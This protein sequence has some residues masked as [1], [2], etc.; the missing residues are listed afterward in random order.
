MKPSP[1]PPRRPAGPSDSLRRQ[2]SMSA[3]AA[4]AA[5][6]GM[7]PLGQPVEAKVVY[8]PAH[9]WL[10]LNHW[11]D[12]DLNHD[13]VN[14][15]TFLLGSRASTTGG[16]RRLSVRRVGASQSQNEIYTSSGGL[17]GFCS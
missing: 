15:F 9:K 13:G 6:V 2:L 8:T 14:D 3:L 4:S 12:L 5:G 7:L 10:P 1:K 16:S 11:Y 17:G